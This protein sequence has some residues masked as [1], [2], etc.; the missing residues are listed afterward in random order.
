MLEL[1]ILFIFQT[2]ETNYSMWCTLNHLSIQQKINM[3]E[4]VQQILEEGNFAK[5]RAREMDQDDFFAL[6]L[7]FNKNNIRFTNSL[8]SQI[9]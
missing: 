6:L 4:K 7:A 2:L 5:K 3:K 9:L 8:K 1:I